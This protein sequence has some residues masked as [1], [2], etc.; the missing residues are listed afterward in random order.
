MAS[1]HGAQINPVYVYAYLK[2]EPLPSTA[3]TCI[4]Q[5]LNC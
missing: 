5:P 1:S 2:P 3:S 4:E